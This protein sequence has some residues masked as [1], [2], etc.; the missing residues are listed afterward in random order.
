MMDQSRWIEVEFNALRQEILTFGEAERSAV[1]FYVPAAAAVYAAPYFLLQQSPSLL[2]DQRHQ[3]FLW[4]FCA[5]VAGLLI[6]ALLHT[7]YWTVNAARR[8]GAYIKESIEP[9]T[10]GGLR[11]ETVFHQLSQKRY[12]WPSDAAAV[13][14]AAVLANMVASAA[15]SVMFLEGVNQIWP[16]LASCFFTL[17]SLPA[18]RRII[19]SAESRTEYVERISKVIQSIETRSEIASPR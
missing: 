17:I 5:A 16:T 15:A 6:L 2:A 4:T 11:W 8:I 9:R 18:I 3:A 13:A 1:K 19:G 14:A 10:N 12:H 7:L